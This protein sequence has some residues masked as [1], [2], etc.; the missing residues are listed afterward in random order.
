[1]G[2][3]II[4]IFCSLLFAAIHI[5]Q[6]Y[7]KSRARQHIKISRVTSFVLFIIC[8]TLL[9]YFITELIK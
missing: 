4:F 2:I 7:F 3:V 8:Y 6:I 1:M 5:Y 9:I